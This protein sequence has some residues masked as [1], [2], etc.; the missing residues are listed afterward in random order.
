MLERIRLHQ[1]NSAELKAFVN[2]RVT[3][4][5]ELNALVST[6]RELLASFEK[7]YQQHLTAIR[8]QEQK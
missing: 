4:S 5:A 2:E 8:N 7:T 3:A 6:L 1:I